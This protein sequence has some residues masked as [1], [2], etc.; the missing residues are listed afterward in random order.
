MVTKSASLTQSLVRTVLLIATG[1]RSVVALISGQEGVQRFSNAA[2]DAPP[3]SPEFEVVSIKPF[4]RGSGPHW[5]GLVPDGIS[6]Q[7]MPLKSLLQA[8]FG[9]EEDRILSAPGW[10]K[11]DE[12]DIVAQVAG[13]DV[14]TWQKQTFSQRGLA[15]RPILEDRFQLKFHYETKVL[16]FYVLAIAKGGSKMKEFVPPGDAA[17]NG[18]RLVGR[19]HLEA[20]GISTGELIRDLSKQLSRTVVDKTGLTGKYNFALQWEPEDALAFATGGPSGQPGNDNASPPDSGGASLL[21]ALREQLGLKL[22]P[23]KG[24]VSVIV[25]DHIETPSPN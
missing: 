19:G 10:V 21:T 6:I 3:L 4:K 7:G 23:Q 20:Q 22:E 2:K 16:P 1:W 13:P 12:F 8:A 9:V 14:P 15:L 24:P 5:L 25:I 18:L 11:T 17:T